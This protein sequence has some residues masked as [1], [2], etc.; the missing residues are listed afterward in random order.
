MH[1]THT[2]VPPSTAGS[3]DS[4]D[5]IVLYPV[6][7]GQLYLTSHSTKENIVRAIEGHPELLFFST[8]EP[9]SYRGYCK[10]FGPTD[11]SGVVSFCRRIRTLHQEPRL[12]GRPVVYSTDANSKTLS[13]AAFLLGAYLVLVKGMCPEDAAAPFTRIQ[14]S[15]FKAFRDAT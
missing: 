9:E 2:P 13:N 12:C 14:P 5:W 10:D 6:V 15:P 7:P 11:L 8:P 1:D 4:V 3:D